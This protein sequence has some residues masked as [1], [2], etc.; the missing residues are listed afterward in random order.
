MEAKFVSI[1][2]ACMIF[3][4]CNASKQYL[5]AIKPTNFV[6]FALWHGASYISKI[7]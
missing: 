2:H 5:A 7:D 3:A 6:P 4:Y 1:M